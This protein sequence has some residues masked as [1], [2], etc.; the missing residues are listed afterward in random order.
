MREKAQRAQRNGITLQDRVLGEPRLLGAADGRAAWRRVANFVNANRLVRKV[1]EKAAGI[2]AEFPLPPFATTTVREVARRS[3]SRCR[4]RRQAR[5]GR[6]LRDVPRRLQLPARRRERRARAREERLR[7][8]APASRRAAGCRTS[9]AATSTRRS[10]K[11]RRNVASLLAEVEQG[12]TIVV[13]AA[14][15]RRTRS[16]RSGPSSSAPPRRSSVAARTFDVMEFLEQLRR[17]KTL[18]ARLQEGARQGRVPRG[19]PPPRAED[20]LPRR[21]RPRRS[22]PTPR[23]RS[24]SSAPRSTAPGG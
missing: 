16:R 1:N 19:L 21:A 20:R 7:G 9:T 13:A 15:V 11:A 17:D 22:S 18:D 14:D 12:R 24:S 6:A 8:R 2:S 4:R 3:T 10:A 5:H 23:S